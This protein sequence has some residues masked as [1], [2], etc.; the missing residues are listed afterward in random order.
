[1]EA[2][3]I[4]VNE[5]E[6]KVVERQPQFLPQSITQVWTG[7]NLNFLSAALINAQEE[8]KGQFNK[9]FST[10][11]SD[12]ALLELKDVLAL[13]TMRLNLLANRVATIL[14]GKKVTNRAAWLNLRI[15]EAITEINK[16][17]H[18]LPFLELIT[19]VMHPTTESVAVQLMLVSASISTYIGQYGVGDIKSPAYSLAEHYWNALN[20][21]VSKDVKQ[22]GNLMPERIQ[23][24]LQV[25]ETLQKE[26]DIH[27]LLAI[28]VALDEFR[29]D[30]KTQGIFRSLEK[31][32]AKINST[33]QKEFSLLS[34]N[35]PLLDSYHRAHEILIP[36]AGAYQARWLAAN[37]QIKLAHSVIEIFALLHQILKKKDFDNVLQLYKEHVKE[38]KSAP[39]K[40]IIT[41]AELIAAIPEQE[42]RSLIPIVYQ[43]H[44]P[45]QLPKFI[46][47]EFE[48]SILLPYH[49]KLNS[50]VDLKKFVKRQEKTV[51]AMTE[52]QSAIET[53]FAAHQKRIKKWLSIHETPADI[54]QLIAS[55]L[56]VPGDTVVV[57]TS[58]ELPISEKRN[59]SSTQNFTLFTTHKETARRHKSVPIGELPSLEVQPLTKLA[60]EDEPESTPRSS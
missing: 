52:E 3:K 7:D 54:K 57:G 17:M 2:L 37:E 29:S 22:A 9:L 8:I 39:N 11:G 42:L 40:A 35:M 20:Y 26:K 1:M 43:S 41:L 51:A 12:S 32:V 14:A 48:S 56:V 50:Y 47:K 4:A 45:E 18:L 44:T 49:Q 16:E 46:V 27:S 25:I 53:K 19:K 5:K 28:N 23:F 15:E 13:S 6:L 21:Y 31:K 55:Q 24:W 58:K 33:I 30:S 38:D 59:H 34:T 60:E 10:P 36:Y